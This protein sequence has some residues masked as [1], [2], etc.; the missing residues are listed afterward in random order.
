[1]GS[2]EGGGAGDVNRT[3]E[4]DQYVPLDLNYI[5]TLG[6]EVRIVKEQGRCGHMK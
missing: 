4:E 5:S 1:M 6:K 2:G 3:S